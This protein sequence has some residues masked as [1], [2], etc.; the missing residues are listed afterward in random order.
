MGFI[1]EPEGVD[2]V[3][4]PSQTVEKDVV[5]ISNYIQQHKTQSETI[6]REI[7]CKSMSAQEKLLNK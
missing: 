6:R 4:A 7:D 2:F 5:V 3:I 1:R